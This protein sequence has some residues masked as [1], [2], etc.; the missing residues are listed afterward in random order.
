MHARPEFH[1][2]RERLA[3]RPVLRKLHREH[4][5]GAT[6]FDEA[7]MPFGERLEPR[8]QQRAHALCIVDQVALEQLADRG[9]PDRARDGISGVRMAGAELHVGLD[10]APER[11]RH[12][13]LDQDA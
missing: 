2:L 9:Q 12:A 5:A 10:F 3:C 13:L 6:H 8:L 4:Q 11:L 7:R 1:R